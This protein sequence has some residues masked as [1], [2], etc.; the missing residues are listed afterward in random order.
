MLGK[1]LLRK[2]KSVV[3][4]KGR[5]ATTRALRTSTTTTATSSL[6]LRRGF[7]TSHTARTLTEEE[8]G[9]STP[10]S[11]IVDVSDETWNDMVVKASFHKLII[12]DAWAEYV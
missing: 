4:R 10:V 3:P 9:E 12:V 8:A 1:L 6:L 7:H 5:G 11:H 2:S